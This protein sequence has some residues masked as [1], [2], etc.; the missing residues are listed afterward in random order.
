[1]INLKGQDPQA[2]ILHIS[3]NQDNSCFSCGE[4]NGFFVA[5]SN[6]LKERFRRGTIR[7][8]ICAY[9]AEFDAGFGEVEMLHKCNILA[10]VGGGT[11]PKY[12]KN[13]VVIWDDFQVQ[14]I[15][16]LAFQSEV[17]AVRMRRDRYIVQ[18]L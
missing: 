15:A 16:E 10:L 8:R 6:P 13:K 1:M 14:S 17:K 5:D 18:A 4:N 3:F 7:S 11:N 9:T 2:P 12:P